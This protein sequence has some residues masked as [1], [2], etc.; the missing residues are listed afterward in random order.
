MLIWPLFLRSRLPVQ[1][2]ETPPKDED[3]RPSRI[4]KQCSSSEHEIF[5]RGKDGDPTIEPLGEDQA[6]YQHPVSYSGTYHDTSPKPSQPPSSK[7]K[8]T[9]KDKTT[10]F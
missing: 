4:K 10:S 1:E 9:P 3:H 2:L 5:H 8:P 7:H 6:K